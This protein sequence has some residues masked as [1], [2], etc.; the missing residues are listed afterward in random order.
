MLQFTLVNLTSR[1]SHINWMI[2]DQYVAL[3]DKERQDSS[4]AQFT[5]TGPTG[6]KIA[7]MLSPV[8]SGVVRNLRHGVHNCVLSPLWYA[9]FLI[10]TCCWPSISFPAVLTK[11]F[12][13]LFAVILR[14]KMY[15]CAPHDAFGHLVLLAH[16]LA[17]NHWEIMYFPLRECVRTPRTLCLR[18]CPLICSLHVCQIA[19][20]NS[21]DHDGGHKLSEIEAVT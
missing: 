17:R 13:R 21:N 15:N 2:F 5:A 12:R 9:D 3:A 18:H 10:Q 8:D 20:N 4:T 7:W 1:H 19:D 16:D 6:P 14:T 11:L